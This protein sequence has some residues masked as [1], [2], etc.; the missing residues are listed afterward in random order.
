MNLSAHRPAHRVLPS[1]LL[2]TAA[3][4]AAADVPALAPAYEGDWKNLEGPA[5]GTMRINLTVAA[6]GTVSGTY[7]RD[8]R[9][10]STGRS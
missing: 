10:C 6:D 2:A 1:L 9:N 3:T 8:A 5:N 7:I 4:C